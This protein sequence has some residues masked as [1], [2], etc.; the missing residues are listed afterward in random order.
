MA[1]SS[2]TTTNV[3]MSKVTNPERGW[4]L[5]IVRPQVQSGD[6]HVN[7]VLYGGLKS[8]QRFSRL[9]VHAG[10]CVSRWTV[11]E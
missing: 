6:E 8:K 11:T 9:L 2:T 1:V 7:V 5:C 4:L 3:R 10:W